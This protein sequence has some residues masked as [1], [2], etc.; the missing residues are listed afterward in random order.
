MEVGKDNKSADVH[1]PWVIQ[2]V[3]IKQ[4]WADVFLVLPGFASLMFSGEM[5]LVFLSV[6]Y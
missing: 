4:A 5:S 2:A 1:D 6:F 3:S